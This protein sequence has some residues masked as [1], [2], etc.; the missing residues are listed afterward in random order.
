MLLADRV[1]VVCVKYSS[2]KFNL[3]KLNKLL[4]QGSRR[5]VAEFSD[6]IHASGILRESCYAEYVCKTCQ[7]KIKNGASVH[8]IQPQDVSYPNCETNCNPGNCGFD[9]ILDIFKNKK[10]SGQNGFFIFE[11]AE[12]PKISEIMSSL[13]VHSFG[14][15]KENEKF[16]M[17]VLFRTK[18]N[19]IYRELPETKQTTIYSLE[20]S[21]CEV[22]A[23]LANRIGLKLLVSGDL[24]VSVIQRNIKNRF[25]LGS[26]SNSRPWGQYG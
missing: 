24:K 22:L 12:L 15:A 6:T 18:T 25:H 10:K 7:K 9:N 13:M 17:L 21:N 19:V 3:G 26:S 11:E 16:R 4:G 2:P 23:E 20:K 8:S 1:C 5:K 14:K